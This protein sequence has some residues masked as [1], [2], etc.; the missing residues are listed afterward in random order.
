MP[1]PGHKAFLLPIGALP[2]PQTEAFLVNGQF[3]NNS[4]QPVVDVAQIPGATSTFDAAIEPY[5]FYLDTFQDVP[6]SWHF[7]TAG[8]SLPLFVPLLVIW[9]GYICCL[10]PMAL[11]YDD[12]VEP[13]T[14]I[15]LL[16][17]PNE[18]STP[19]TLRSLLRYSR[20][21]DRRYRMM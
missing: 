7:G 10:A 17:R 2:A 5:H 18:P 19:E 20:A 13:R 3:Q 4:G 21:E 9:L 16:A 1:A 14:L 6:A 15:T 8:A 12:T 11:L